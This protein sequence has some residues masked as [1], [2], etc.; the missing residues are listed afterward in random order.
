[1][2]QTFL[3]VAEMVAAQYGE[4]PQFPAG[5]STGEAILYLAIAVLYLAGYWK[6]FA[7]A[8]KPGWATIVPIYNVV[9]YLQVVGRPIWWIIL[10]LIPIVNVVVLIVLTHDLS[11]AFGKGVGYTLG[12]I[13]LG[14]VFPLV[15]GFGSDPYVGRRA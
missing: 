5:P 14:P 2:N 10:L 6:I 3:D 8:G 13:F 9:V 4:S 7:K 11:R 1:M 12:L 15:L